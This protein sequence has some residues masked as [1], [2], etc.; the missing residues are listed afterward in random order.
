MILMQHYKLKVK[1]LN[2]SK[3]PVWR[4]VLVPRDC[5]FDDLHHVIQI[6]M[7]WEFAH[8]YQFILGDRR[9]PIYVNNFDN[10][11]IGLGDFFS[12]NQIDSD[13]TL[14]ADYLKKKKDK[15]KYEYDFGDSW[16]HEVTL[17]DFVEAPIDQQVPCVLRG[18]GA[19]PPEDCGG[20]WGYEHLKTVISNPKL[21][22]YEEFMEWLD[23]DFDPKE[24]DIDEVNEYLTERTEDDSDPNAFNLGEIGEYLEEIT[25]DV[26]GH[27]IGNRD[28]S[29]VLINISETA[30]K[31]WSKEQLKAAKQE[32]GTLVDLEIPYIKPD[33]SI[34]EIQLIIADF[35]QGIY[36][37]SPKA[38][39]I[40]G[41][42]AFFFYLIGLLSQFEIPCIE[43]TFEKQIR[44]TPEGEKEVYYTFCQF[45]S[46]F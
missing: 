2:V 13:K 24:F 8:L 4:E 10:N 5:T 45:R 21:A 39:H 33:L 32:Y 9:N 44:L 14:I 29:D 6:A 12:A 26:L 31:D 25:D 37:L 23:D 43:S 38:V 19:C 41:K 16:M 15:F 35:F 7:G 34:D 11:S 18:K 30:T 22:E 36:Q 27:L 42:G 46:Y 40:S 1:L 20:V 28:V 3:P 17:V